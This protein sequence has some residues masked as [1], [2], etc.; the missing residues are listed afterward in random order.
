M[1]DMLVHLPNILSDICWAGVEAGSR[2][3][4]PGLLCGQQESNYLIN[5]TGVLT[6]EAATSLSIS[7]PWAF[8][9][10]TEYEYICYYLDEIS[11]KISTLS[12][13]IWLFFPSSCGFKFLYSDIKILRHHWMTHKFGYMILILHKLSCKNLADKN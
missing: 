13:H 9:S 3:L 12:K 7:F 4:N 5:K 11:M 10:A 6:H 8:W 1:E 2:E